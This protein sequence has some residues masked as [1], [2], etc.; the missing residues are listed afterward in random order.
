MHSYIYQITTEKQEK[1]CFITPYTVNDNP[2]HFDYTDEL[3]SEKEIDSAIKN[4]ANILPKTMFECNGRE[5]TYKGY[6]PKV[7]EE[8]QESMKEAIDCCSPKAF[9]ATKFSPSMYLYRI[10]TAVYELIDSSS[11]FVTDD[12]LSTIKNTEFILDC[13]SLLSPG[14]KLYVGGVLDY[15]F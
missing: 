15:H 3:D 13:I 1:D 12:S 9:N 4:L 11:L 14:D 6:D 5:I 2:D 7:I 8:W 10:K